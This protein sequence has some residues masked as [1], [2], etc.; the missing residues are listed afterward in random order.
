MK[1]E[2]GG[3]EEER[4]G[5]RMTRKR[6]CA[7]V[8]HLAVENFGVVGSVRVSFTGAPASLTVGGGR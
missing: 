3:E 8:M 5:G 4:A 6:W 2:G 7:A 1:G